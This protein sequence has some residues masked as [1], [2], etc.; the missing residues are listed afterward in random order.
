[1]AESTQNVEKERFFFHKSLRK[2][3]DCIKKI[4]KE[5]KFAIYKTSLVMFKKRFLHI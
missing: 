3:N 2:V 4:F 5:V 1:M